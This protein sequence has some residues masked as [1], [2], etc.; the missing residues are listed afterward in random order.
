MANDS[1][2]R[3][4]V[5]HGTALFPLRVHE[6]T[7]DP[8]VIDR[9]PSHWH[10]EVEILVVTRGTAAFHLDGT[11]QEVA[12]G[13]VVFIAPDRLHGFTAPVGTPFAFYAVVF[14]P[15]F[16]ASA[17]S[18][19]L[20]LRYLDPVLQGE[21]QFPSVIAAALSWQ[22]QLRTQLAA[23]RQ[24]AGQPI[25]GY[26]LVVKAE[27]LLAWAT[28]VRHTAPAQ[29]QVSAQTNQINLVKNVLT[30]IRTHLDQPLSAAF[31]AKQFAV[32]ESH[33]CRLFKAVTNSTLTASI[34]AARI[35][36]SAQLLSETSLP[37]GEVASRC[38]FST[39]SYF[40]VRFRQ[41]LHQTPSAFRQARR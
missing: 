38:G 11:R 22:A 8:G 37:I 28:L 17:V 36:K 1:A 13:D 2:L 18:D 15:I 9:V 31:L 23:I 19:T 26:E 4:K 40:N 3:E 29:A 33:L 24:T 32:S 25:T 35:T 30:F 5:S 20:Q 41:R 12:A 16:I 39:I 7:S 27:L 34:T 6:F 21:Q 10:P 14:D